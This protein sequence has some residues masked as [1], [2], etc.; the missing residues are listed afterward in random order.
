MCE[1]KIGAGAWLARALL[2]AGMQMANPVNVLLPT[3]AGD[4]GTCS[5][6]LSAPGVLDFSGS[7]ITRATQKLFKLMNMQ[8]Q[9]LLADCINAICSHW[10]RCKELIT[11][12]FLL[13][14]VRI[15]EL[16]L[17]NAVASV[18]LQDD[19]DAEDLGLLK[20]R[21]TSRSRRLDPVTKAKLLEKRK[22]SSV[23]TPGSDLVNTNKGNR[24][25]CVKTINHLQIQQTHLCFSYCKS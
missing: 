25:V 14:L 6:K 16:L 24:G 7:A 12:G 2:K 20:T 3:C 11:E 21:G 5:V 10:A 22:E 23:A 9:M 15:A 18:A 1:A 19:S 13:A 8:T 4:G 17:N